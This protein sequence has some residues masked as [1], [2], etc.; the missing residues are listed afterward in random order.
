MRLF[1]WS[2]A[3]DD[4]TPLQ[5]KNFL[6]V[7]IDAVGIGLSAA[8]APFLPVFLTRLGATNFQ[9]G[10]LTSMPAVTGLLFSLSAGHFLQT[11]RNIVPWF[12]A[13]RL[14][15]ISAYAL[16]G[17]IPFVVPRDLVV[18]AVLLIW[19]LATIPQ[20]I[21][22]IAFSVV[23]NAVAGPRG[24]YDL[25][26][27][28]W[29]ILGVTTAVSVAIVGQILD[30]ISFPVNYQIAFVAVSCGGLMSYY[31]SSHIVLPD[32]EQRPDTARVPRQNGLR[33]LFDLV[34]GQTEFISFTRNR[35]VYTLGVV[36]TA[37][38]FPLYYVRLLHA[39]DSWIGFFGTAQT[40]ATLLGYSLWARLSRSRGSRFA[41][42]C[43]T[44]AMSL[45]PA[46]VAGTRRLEV[47]TLWAGLAGVFQAGVDLVFFDELMRTV[48]PQHSATFVAYAASLQ[49]L[50]S[51]VGPFLGTWMADHTTLPLALSVAALIRLTGFGL[52]W[53]SSRYSGTA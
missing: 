51:V 16:T 10:L 25:M 28:R 4:A 43:T 44:L 6:N 37:P 9:V 14:L 13:A 38:L 29:S 52:F 22:N 7:Q 17:L 27:R 53:K 36:L 26:S 23:M 11:R 47:I 15:V 46:L 41:L 2:V 31:Y 12:S 32:S 1:R 21:V 39:P 18:Q 20:T 5:R 48:P 8:A 42:L 3:P 40:A 33:G 45:Y 34:R 49:Y 30:R 19:A 24:R 35:F 50:A